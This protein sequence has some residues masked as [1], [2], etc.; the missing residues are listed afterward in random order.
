MEA[1]CLLSLSTHSS[2]S[3]KNGTFKQGS[4]RHSHLR[5][6]PLQHDT[7]FTQTGAY[8]IGFQGQL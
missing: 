7:H 2:K 4:Q 6:K 8:S 1:L 3:P 5:F